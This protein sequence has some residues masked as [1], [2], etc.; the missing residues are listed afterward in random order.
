MRY[1]IDNIVGDSGKKYGIGV[2]LDSDLL[3]GL[4][5]T[6]RKQMVKLRVVEEFADS[7]VIAYDNSNVPVE[8]NFAR[9]NDKIKTKA[10]NKKP[11]LKELY[12]KNINR[13]IKQEA[14]ALADELITASKQGKTNSAKHNHDWLDN[15]GKNKW[16]ERTVYIQETN[17]AVWKATLHIANAKDGRKILYDIDPIKMVE[18]TRKSVPTTTNN[19]IPNS[20]GNVNKNSL[21]KADVHPTKRGK[22][23][24]MGEEVTLIAPMQSNDK[25]NDNAKALAPI[26]KNASKKESAKA[27]AP[28]RKEVIAKEIPNISEADLLTTGADKN[29]EHLFMTNILQNVLNVKNSAPLLENESQM[30]T[31]NANVTEE[32]IAVIGDILPSINLIYMN[33]N[34]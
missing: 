27:L 19:I 13:E 6:E 30:E 26:G 18:E 9:K 29:N 15:Y 34:C 28:I 23:N 22:Y 12:N 21:S 33:R 14:V 11:V 1:S 8:I 32:N 3:T 17:N 5:E 4:N 2:R 31:D 20:N 25:S 7:S 16:D 24:V 10:G